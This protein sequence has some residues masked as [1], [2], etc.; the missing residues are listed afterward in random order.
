[1]EGGVEPKEIMRIAY[2]H[3]KKVCWHHPEW[4][5]HDLAGD[6]I[7]ACVRWPPKYPAE[8]TM[9]AKWATADW[10]V[11][12]MG[13]EGQKAEINC[14]APFSAFKQPS[15]DDREDYDR[16][17]ATDDYEAIHDSSVVE[18]MIRFLND[19]D[20][21]IVNMISSGYSMQDIADILGTSKA[22][23]SRSVTDRIRPL[24]ELIAS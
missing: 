24:Y 5:Q 11:R 18:A 20:A 23:V 1:M 15:G 19:R 3:A 14:A 16:E 2:A 22:T 9:R 12:R 4:D 17:Q 7:E 8:V 13:R 10:F 21:K 6:I